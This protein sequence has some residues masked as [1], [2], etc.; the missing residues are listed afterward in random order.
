MAGYVSLPSAVVQSWALASVVVA[1]T[2]GSALAGQVLQAFAASRSPVPV[3]LAS[4]PAPLRFLGERSV[5]FVV[6]FGG[7]SE[8]TLAFAAGSL[9]AG[10]PVV[11]VT[12]G[13]LLAHLVDREGGLVIPIGPSDAAGATPR[14]SNSSMAATLV[15]LLLASEQLGLF[16]DAAV[17]LSA[18]CAQLARRSSSLSRGGGRAAE[19]ARLLGRTIPIVHGSSGLGAVAARL[20]KARVNT[21]AKAPAYCGAHP[22]VA[23][24][25]LSGFGQHGDVTR[26]VLSL[27][28]L[29]TGLEDLRTRRR[30]DLFA[31]MTS[32]AVARVI[33]VEAHGTGELARFFDLA[34]IGEFVSLHLA[35]REGVDPGPAVALDDFARRLAQ[36]PPGVP[37]DGDSLGRG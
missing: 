31:E 24:D 20:W 29:R 28:N 4:P 5:V 25:E 22:E 32:E 2:G 19:I 6:S 36:V 15:P 11:A 14:G 21:N 3:L 17:E 33:D 7:D 34:M 8:E 1:G 12:S 10:A 9:S 27:V 23:H 30:F 26:Q 35:A 13:G 16:G 18:A 37:V